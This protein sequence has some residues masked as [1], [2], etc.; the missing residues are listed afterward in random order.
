MGSGLSESDIGLAASLHLFAAFGVSFPVD[1]NGRQF[2]ESPYAGSPTVVV[3]G[4][5]ARLP[6]GP[7][8][9]IEVD[10]QMV[11]RLAINV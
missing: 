5:R 4:G 11:R 3:E 1:L 7:G 10:E 9:G 2:F 8:L 6:D